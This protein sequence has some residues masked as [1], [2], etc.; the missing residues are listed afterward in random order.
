MNKL[1]KLLARNDVLLKDMRALADKT[2]ALTEDEETKYEAAEKEFEAN[3]KEILRLQKLADLE[4][5][6][7]E[8]VNKPVVSVANEPMP[9]PFKSLVQQLACVKNAA[10]GNGIDPRL[11]KVQEIQNAQGGNVGNPSEGG[12]AVQTDFAGMMMESAASSGEI[13]SR[14]DSYQVTDGSDSV[15]WIDIDEDDVSST[16]FGGVRVYW[17]AEAAAVTKSHPKLAEKELK[18]QKLMGIA[19]ATYELESDSSFVNTLYTRAFELAIRRALEGAIVSGDGVGKPL[20]FLNSKSLVT[21]AKETNQPAATIL[22]KNLSKMYHRILDK[23]GGV[24]LAH[25]DAHEQFDFLEFPVGT[26]GVPVYLPATQTGSIDTLRGKAI[27]ESDHCAAL[28]SKGDINFVD[29]NQYMMAYKG[30]VDAATSIHVQFLTAENCFRFIFRANGMPKRN[31]TL[32]IKNSSNVRSPFITL[33]AR[34]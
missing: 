2:E 13:L 15:K 6:A 28:G 16:V 19:Y 23:S 25:P 1:E 14:V 11:A 9:K 33:A 34:A 8:P 10:N 32:T 12:F 21:I 3:E 30:G 4:A 20:G 7:T 17:A 27:A 26:G 18:L 5:K 22:W 31:S 24:W 29:L